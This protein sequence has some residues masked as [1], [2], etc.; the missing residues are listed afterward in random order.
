LYKNIYL[1]NFPPLLNGRT[2]KTAVKLGTDHLYQQY[3]PLANLQLIIINI[4]SHVLHFLSPSN[5]QIQIRTAHL[6][7]ELAQT[8]PV[9]VS[10]KIT[11][12]SLLS[13][14]LQPSSCKQGGEHADW[15]TT[16]VTMLVGGAVHIRRKSY[17]N[18]KTFYYF[19]F[20]CACMNTNY[21]RTSLPQL[22][23]TESQKNCCLKKTSICQSGWLKSLNES[24]TTIG[25]CKCNQQLA[26]L[27]WLHSCS[28]CTECCII[29]LLSGHCS[30][31]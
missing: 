22:S 11:C 26:C 2:Q 20:S 8:S 13:G 29:S 27:S 7:L 24:S 30:N 18:T 19:S 3:F 9:A 15:Q 14:L 4:N 5:L 28:I 6:A 21:Y 12:L 23:A 10:Y 25:R 1:Q 17:T 31:Q 16:A